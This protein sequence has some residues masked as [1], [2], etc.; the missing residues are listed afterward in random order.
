MKNYVTQIKNIPLL[1]AGEKQKLL[2]EAQRGSR[3][4]SNKLVE[5]HLHLPMKVAF[6]YKGM[7]GLEIED[8]INIASFG[9]IQAVRNYDPNKGVS[10]D[11]F[12]YL[13]SE[14]EVIAYYRTQIRQKRDNRKDYSLQKPI[15]I[16][17]NGDKIILEDSLKS[18]AM[19]DKEVLD[20]IKREILKE[21]LGRLDEQE[22]QW[23]ELKYGLI[24]GE[25][26][27]FEEIGRMESIAGER[28]RVACVKA[29]KKLRNPRISKKI[30]DFY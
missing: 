24:D 11:N 9:L 7:I 1:D 12:A 2:E 16:G 13:C 4:A 28:V 3:S 21:V 27:S 26:F 15:K 18:S 30:K 22:R 14:R 19:V 8:I 5:H 10:F 20:N 6:K 23:L 25:C 17:N 29:L